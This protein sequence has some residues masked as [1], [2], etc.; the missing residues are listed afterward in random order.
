[1]KKAVF[2]FI[3]I[4]LLTSNLNSFA[5]TKLKGIIYG[6]NESK[7][8]IPL[9]GASLRWLETNTGTLSQNNGEFE[10]SRT[11]DNKLLIVS[12]IGYG[13]D[14]IEVPYN[15]TFLE[16]TLNSNLELNEIIV[17]AHQSTIINKS[18]IEKSETITM[19]GLRKAACCNLGESFQT[20]ASVDVEYT[21]AVSGAKQIKLLGLDGSY[22]Q[23]MTEKIPNLRGI[24]STYGLNYIPGPWMEAISISKGASSVTTGYESITGQ[25]DVDYKKPHTSEPLFI[26]LFSDQFA[27]LEADMN[28]NYHF[29]DILSTMLLLH[30]NS[31][32]YK[33]DS[34][35]DGFLDLPLNDQINAMN[36]WNFI[37]DNTHIQFAIKGLYENRNGGQKAFYDNPFNHYGFN[38]HTE[39]YE[40]LWKSGYIFE[41]ENYKSIAL[42]LSAIDHKQFATFGYRNYNGKQ[43]SLYANLIYEFVFETNQNYDLNTLNHN[44]STTIN[45]EL[46]HKISLGLS[47]QFDEYDETFAN[48]NYYRNENIPG[49]FCEY[50]LKEI[51]G[52]TLQIGTRLD[53]HNLFGNFFTPRFHL[54]YNLNSAT[55]I[56]ASIG[57]GY[58]IANIF[59]E[60]SGVMASSRQFIIEENLNPETAW[61]YGLNIT[62]DFYINDIASTI[63][64]DFYRTDFTNQVIFDLERDP[65]K[66]YFY[67]LKGKSYSNSFQINLIFEPIDGLE[68]NTAYRLNDVKMTFNGKLLQKP[69]IP[70]HKGFLNLAYK[71]TNNNWNFDW[72]FDLNGGGR[73]PN[74]SKNPV[75]YQLE[76]EFPPYLLLHA[77]IEKK[78][79][80]F[81]I[82]LGAENLTNYKQQNP[83]LAANEPFSNYFD[84]SIIWAPIE[85]RKIYL[86]IRIF[87]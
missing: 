29:D 35:N 56:R 45:T 74:T 67:N 8:K 48:S 49:I 86:G 76:K 50:T 44:D 33:H 79:K 41:S 52:L 81:S 20:N 13:K 30:A 7:E 25:I 75:E 65:S 42:I 18:N 40:V 43:K 62:N 10:I 22:T 17:E 66:A 19:H 58:H 28:T 26:N 11:N 46:Q 31:M 69:L 80:S 60:H 37:N 83:I 71:T 59:A 51:Y 53:K 57:K 68:I 21:D 1:M 32:Q 4:L 63:I 14:T 23:I 24:S 84:S 27:R 2:K 85:G 12:F 54:K 9:I 5:E 16:I 36:R 64:I 82:Y 72:T 77:Q 15:K 38:I 61:N 70:K 39:R 3:I 55:I 73:L 87:P 6:I 78:F 47:W 34:N